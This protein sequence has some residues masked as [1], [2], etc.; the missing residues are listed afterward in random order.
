MIHLALNLLWIIGCLIITTWLAALLGF[1][2]WLA[3]FASTAVIFFARVWSLKLKKDNFI[4]IALATAAFVLFSI[5]F[6]TFHHGLPTGDSQKTIFFSQIINQTNRLPDYSQAISL[7]NR[8]PIDFA[9]PGLHTFTALILKLSGLPGV[10]FAAIIISLATALV[11]AAITAALFPSLKL[12]P[13]FTF[14]LALTNFRF[15][16]YLREPGYHYQ[17]IF[18]EFLLWGLLLLLIILIKKFTIRDFILLIVIS[19]A[20]ILTHQFSSFLAAFALA[21]AFLLLLWHHRQN[22]LKLSAQNRPLITL[23][24]TMLISLIIIPAFLLDV[25]TKLTHLFSSAP[26]L[27]ELTPNLSD[28]P[29]LLGLPFFVFGLAGLALLIIKRQK[30][31]PGLLAFIVTTLI[32]FLFSQGPRLRIDI[33]P[34]RALLYLVIPLSITISYL[35]H[36]IISRP[37]IWNY[38]GLTLLFISL[39]IPSLTQA[40]QLSHSHP[41]NSTLTPGQLELINYITSHDPKSAIITDD[42]NRR[43]TSWL[44]LTHQPTL[45]RVTDM[46]RQMQ[47]SNQTA[48]RQDLY[49]KQLDYEKIYNLGSRTALNHLLDK[50]HIN[51]LVGV[52]NSSTSNFSNHP[53]LTSTAQADGLTLYYY[54]ST[55]NPPPPTPLDTWL[56]KPSTLVNDIGDQED[57]FLRLPASLQA[58]RLS[59]PII[60]SP[61][62]TYRLTTAPTINLSFNVGAFTKNLIDQD[63]NNQPDASLELLVKFTSPPTTPLTIST[64]K[65]T[66]S[67]LPN[68]LTNIPAASLNLDENGFATFT[69]HNPQQLPLEFDLI[70]LGTSQIP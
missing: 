49:L 24:I 57:T 62:Q 1:P 31:T 36:K 34:V 43:S 28:Y 2:G 58:T 6:L 19:L 30:Q 38:L 7:L 4:I 52:D 40:Y 56:L 67:L 27:L 48:L 29:R 13:Y 59:D 23:V 26:H 65:S 54:T 18:G 3:I 70:A 64:E 25:P 45:T 51:W 61:H 68:R 15:L 21:P 39:T 47:E 20:L 53:N 55:N 8:D 63:Q 9:T 42:N 46:R 60:N 66:I 33:P 50:H 11:A 22:I 35:L 44:N 69:L 12:A 17:N 5:P 10:G 37:K 41:T 32:L 16:R 14:F